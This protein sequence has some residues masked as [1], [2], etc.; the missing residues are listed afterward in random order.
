MAI[1]DLVYTFNAS[2]VYTTLQILLNESGKWVKKME[3]FYVLR[4]IILPLHVMICG[5]LLIQG[6]TLKIVKPLV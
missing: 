2:F 4:N 6:L 5:D 1:V 3:M